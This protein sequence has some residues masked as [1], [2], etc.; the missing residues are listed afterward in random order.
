[1]REKVLDSLRN[2][3]EYIGRVQIAY[4]FGSHVRELDIFG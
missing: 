2:F 3:F 4:L 1:M